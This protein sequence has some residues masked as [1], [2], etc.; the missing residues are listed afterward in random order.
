MQQDDA[1]IDH[2]IC[3]FSKKFNPHQKNYST[4]EKEALGLILALQ[5]FEAYVGSSSTPVTVYTDQNPLTFVHKMR[6]ENQRL[7]RWSLALQVYNI[8]IKHIKGTQNVVAD[9]LSR[10][11]MD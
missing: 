5:H 4:V 11:P 3:V 1:G 2:P 7:L 8:D 9:A 6:T 10:Q